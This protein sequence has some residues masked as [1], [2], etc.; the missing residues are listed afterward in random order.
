VDDF[1][2]LKGA[3]DS[4]RQHVLAAVEGLDETQLMISMVPSAWTLAGLEPN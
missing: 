3:L 4:Q 2:L 1:E